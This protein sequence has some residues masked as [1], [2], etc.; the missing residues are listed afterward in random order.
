MRSAV[1]VLGFLG[2]VWTQAAVSVQIGKPAPDF[3]AVDSHGKTHRLADYLGKVVVLEW[4]N[5]L[6]SHVR[7]HYDSG[8]IPD[9]QSDAEEDGVIWLSVIS[10]APGKPGHV[11][12][13]WAN[14]LTKTRYASPN[15]VL[16][17]TGGD[18]GRL[19]GARKTPHLFIID[20][21][22]MLVYMGG[23]DSIAS[24]NPADITRATQ[25]VSYALGEIRAG[26]R[27]SRPLTRAYG[28]AVNY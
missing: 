4:T 7:K 11:S 19:Y 3:E 10:S 5:H 1:I 17:D 2:L 20:A 28:C 8:N 15:A 9:Q 26:R 12:A 22:G 23:I 18:L 13:A 27:I 25:Y 16:L 24:A 6:C 14:E 21:R